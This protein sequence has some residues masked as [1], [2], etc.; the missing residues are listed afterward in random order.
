MILAYGDKVGQ[1]GIYD[2]SQHCEVVSR[3]EHGG[4]VTC[5]SY[6]CQDERML[7]SASEDRTR[8]KSNGYRKPLLHNTDSLYS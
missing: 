2:I 5:L 6:D 3:K 7:V 1:I 4:M 8:N